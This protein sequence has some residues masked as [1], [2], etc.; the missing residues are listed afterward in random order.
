[1]RFRWQGSYAIVFE[2]ASEQHS[3][4]DTNDEKLTLPI[5]ASPGFVV[6]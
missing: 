2:Y 6:L 3:S 1:M 5:Y 4:G